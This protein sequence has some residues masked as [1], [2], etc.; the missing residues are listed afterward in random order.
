MK[1]RSFQGSDLIIDVLK[2]STAHTH[3]IRLNIVAQIRHLLD[4]TIGAKS[5]CRID[6]GSVAIVTKVS[7]CLDSM[8]SDCCSTMFAHHQQITVMSLC[9]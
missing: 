6:F 5:I 9:Y 7:H 4:M 3:Q 8:H 1:L 2:V